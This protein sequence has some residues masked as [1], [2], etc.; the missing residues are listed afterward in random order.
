MSNIDI[1]NSMLSLFLL[2]FHN[3]LVKSRDYYLHFI[4]KTESLRN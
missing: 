1:Y 2:S 3:N 4:K